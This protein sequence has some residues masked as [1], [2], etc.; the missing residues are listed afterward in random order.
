LDVPFEEKDAAKDLGAK[1]NA[2]EKTWY[3]PTEAIRQKCEKWLPLTEPTISQTI[4]GP[5]E[6]LVSSTKCYRCDAV[7]KVAAITVSGIENSADEVLNSPLILTHIEHLEPPFIA[8]L[9]SFNHG[10]SKKHSNQLGRDVWMNCCD[11]CGAH[12]GDFFMMNEP[13]GA[14]HPTSSEEARNIQ[15][16]ELVGSLPDPAPYRGEYTT[17]FKESF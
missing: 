4:S 15:R 10:F 13:G 12:F 9:Q 17:D 3:A 5:F 1:W 11:S 16:G 2:D 14:F 7:S 6:I 8:M